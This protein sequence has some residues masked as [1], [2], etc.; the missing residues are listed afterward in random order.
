M[1]E[2]ENA[3]R[4]VL[5]TGGARSG[6]SSFAEQYVASHGTKIAYI[7]TAQIFDD[8]MRYRVKLH[9]ERRPSDWQTYEAPFAAENAI[10]EAVVAVDKCVSEVIE[11]AKANDYEAI[12]IA[13]HG[14]ADNAI[15]EDGTPN[16]A[17]SLNPVPFIYVTDN[18]S[19]TVKDGRLADV[20][21][22][23]L[24]IMGLEQPADMT[25]ENL[26]IDNK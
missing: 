9:R 25:G 11:A 18:N 1:S 15:N 10:A 16:T 5:V 26:I 6:K 8:E 3:G 13:D 20:A 14:N 17:D 19:A 21:P 2:T 7:A 12:I 23:I 22:S 4:L 24:H